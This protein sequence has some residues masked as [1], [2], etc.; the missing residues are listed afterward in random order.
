MNEYDE[1]R[2]F[3]FSKNKKNIQNNFKIFPI[4][5]KIYDPGT[6]FLSETIQTII[7]NSIVELLDTFYE[8]NRMNV[9]D[10]GLFMFPAGFLFVFLS[11]SH[12]HFLRV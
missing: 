3:K 8:L 7:Q 6:F 4:S 5:C 2:N 12:R 1:K 11:F 9:I 10:T